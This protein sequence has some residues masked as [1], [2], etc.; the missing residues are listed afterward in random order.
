MSKGKSEI[1]EKMKR[2]LDVLLDEWVGRD[3]PVEGTEDYEKW[4]SLLMSI[5]DIKDIDSFIEYIEGV[6]HNDPDEFFM[7][8]R[9]EK[10]ITAGLAPEKVPLALVREVGY[11]VGEEMLPEEATCKIFFYDGKYFVINEERTQIVDSENDAFEIAGIVDEPSYNSIL[12]K[13][14]S[15][16]LP[17]TKTTPPS[18]KAKQ[19]R[20]AVLIVVTK[21]PDGTMAVKF[22]Y[23]LRNAL[24]VPKEKMTLLQMAPERIFR[25]ETDV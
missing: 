7:C 23:A 17:I 8:E 6:L 12:D 5:E 2:N 15:V 10:L 4:Q 24:N 13:E 25:V 3:V 18:K 11:P 14:S 22:G 21:W 20:K 1:I 16:H 19:N 9:Y